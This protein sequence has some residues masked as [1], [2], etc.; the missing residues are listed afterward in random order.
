MISRKKN[1]QQKIDTKVPGPQLGVET[2]FD[3]LLL[4]LAAVMRKEFWP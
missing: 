1:A 2:A 3:G 4:M